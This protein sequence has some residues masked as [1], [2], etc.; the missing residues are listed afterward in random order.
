M[1]FIT[2][3]D[4]CY[5]LCLLLPANI[6]TLYLNTDPYKPEVQADQSANHIELIII[7]ALGG[8]EE[9]RTTCLQGG[10]SCGQKT[11]AA[12]SGGTTRVRYDNLSPD[13]TYD[14]T[15][16]ALVG[17]SGT[18]AGKQSNIVNR[19]ATTHESGEKWSVIKHKL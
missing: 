11:Q 15:V 12:E 9:Y 14:F 7:Q 2:P 19:A 10:F 6:C 4:T 3:L 18:F 1:L 13:R 8:T 16:V 17:R 5:I